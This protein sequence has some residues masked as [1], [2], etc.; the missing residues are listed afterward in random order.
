MDLVPCVHCKRHVGETETT[1]PFCATALP[2][3][4][5]QLAF[6][7]RLTRAAIF[8]AAAVSAGAC[9]DSSKSSAA[10]QPTAGSAATGSATGSGSGSADDL[11]K[12]LDANP[13]TVDH[14]AAVTDG[15]V[16][17]AALADAGTP[18]DA[19]TMDEATRKEIIRK[20]REDQG[21][22]QGDDIRKQRQQE[23]EKHRIKIQVNNK[24]YGA[25]P[26]R[27]RIV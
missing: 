23:L 26:A 3:Q 20:K 24:P 16:A 4:R 25:P 14:P 19:G 17:D 5:S 12:M 11:E 27:R 10:L 15:G 9:K 18:G 22:K 1:C 6:A 8:S 2:P 7:A 21:L 13:A